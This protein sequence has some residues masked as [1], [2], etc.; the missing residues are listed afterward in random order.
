[1]VFPFLVSARSPLFESRRENEPAHRRGG[2]YL[3]CS[4]RQFHR[5]THPRDSASQSDPGHNAVPHGS[6]WGPC[7]CL[8]AMWR[9]SS[10]LLQQLSQSSLQQVSRLKRVAGGSTP[11]SRNCFKHVTSTSY[12]RC[13]TNSTRSSCRIRQCS[14]TF[15]SSPWPKHSAKWRAIPSISVRDRFLRHPSHLGTELALSSS[16]S[17]RDS[18]RRNLSR[19]NTMDLPPIPV[20]PA[21]HGSQQ[22]LSSKVCSRTPAGSSKEPAYLCRID[23]ASDRA[24]NVCRISAN[25]VSSELG[26]L[27]QAR[28]R[29]TGAGH[30]LSRPRHPPCRHF[31]PPAHFPR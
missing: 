23:S 2:R 11:G 21:H 16:H 14:I 20:L 18:W 5:Q 26:C 9:R 4:S 1:M 8:S 17:L 25:S 7:R 31:Q 29:R 27:R 13:R 22:S 6:A 15:C 12:S 30:P 3:P 19:W 10:H 24:Q 28:L